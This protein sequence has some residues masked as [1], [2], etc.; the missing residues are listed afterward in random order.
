MA[1]IRA[2]H[3]D[4]ERLSHRNRACLPLRIGTV[5]KAKR[6][7][8]SRAQRYHQ[9]AEPWRLNDAHMK[10]PANGME[11]N[12]LQCFADA[13]SINVSGFDFGTGGTAMQVRGGASW[14]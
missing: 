12:L 2:T 4:T 14:P 6:A 7:G 8:A 5:A 11:L 1:S 13:S 10:S 9:A 3:S